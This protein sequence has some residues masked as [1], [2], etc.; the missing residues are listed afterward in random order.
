MNTN[1]STMNQHQNLHQFD[2]Q[3]PTPVTP[4]L[5]RKKQ[6]EEL[7]ELLQQHRILTITGAGGIGKTRISLEICNAIQQEF[8][9]G[10]FFVSMA[11]LNDA[12]E[13]IPTLADSLGVTEVGG[14]D[15]AEGV[16]SVLSDKKVL[17]TLDNLEHVIS[18]SYEIS[19]LIAQCPNLSVLCTSRTPLKIR[20]EYEYALPPLALPSDTTFDKLLDYPAI[21]L[22]VKCAQKV[23][24]DFELSEE[25]AHEITEICRRIDG[26]PLALELAAA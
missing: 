8:Q 20:A 1:I 9:D 24:R 2:Y 25:N 12:K 16:S 11:T 4:I 26:L 3:I 5:G 15:L 14:R 17:L 22:F 7:S 21:E 18:A 10:I 13:V 19:N 6:V 23:N